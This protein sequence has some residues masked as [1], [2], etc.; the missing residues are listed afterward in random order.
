MLE[1]V[2]SSLQYLCVLQAPAFWL[3]VPGVEYSNRKLLRWLDNY[4]D[5]NIIKRLGSD[6]AE[7]VLRVK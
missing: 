7:V 3:L 1:L 4:D 2:L 6:S 5:N